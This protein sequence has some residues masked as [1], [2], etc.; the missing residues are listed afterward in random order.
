MAARGWCETDKGQVHVNRSTSA[1]LALVLAPLGWVMASF[2]FAALLGDPDPLIPRAAIEAERFRYLAIFFLGLFSIFSCLV[3]SGY[4]V[5][6]AR[7][8][9]WAAITLGVLPLF[10]LCIWALFLQ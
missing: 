8:R 10:A 1:N 6:E 2:G 4:S 9:A 3:L 5:T 7:V